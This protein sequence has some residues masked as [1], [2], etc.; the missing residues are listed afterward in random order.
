MFKRLGMFDQSLGMFQPAGSIPFNPSRLFVAGE[1][2]VWY[3][4]SDFTTMFQDA[5]GTTPAA[6][7]QPVGL[8]RDKSGR[9]NH[10]SQTTLAA[11]PVLKQDANGM[12]YLLFDG[13][14]DCLFTGSI[15]FSATNKVTA[16][17]GVRKLLDAR[18]TLFELGTGSSVGSFAI[19]APDAAAAARY[20]MRLIGDVG[21]GTVATPS[22][23]AAPITN[24]ITPIYDL[25]AAT[26]LTK[27][28][29]RVNGV[30]QAMVNVSGTVGAG[31]FGNYPLYIG[32]RNNNSL[33]WSGRLYSL[34]IRGAQS[35]ASQIVSAEAWVNGKTKAY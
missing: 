30:D 6:L 24:V 10:A 28:D 3:D 17:S 32:R 7:D 11:R 29:M 14:D 26:N 15:N 21:A 4:P 16:W 12:Y 2:G 25:A 33:Q 18:G 34:I 31:N 23:Y 13:I 35:T 8:L 22:S 27:M 20:T 1:Q 5:A 19:E 9:N